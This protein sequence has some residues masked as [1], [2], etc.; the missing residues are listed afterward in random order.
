MASTNSHP[1]YVVHLKQHPSEVSE[2][3]G[4]SKNENEPK[5]RSDIV[6]SVYGEPWYG[7]GAHDFMS[8]DGLVTYGSRGTVKSCNILVKK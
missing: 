1:R 3:G 5:R 7:L 4:A 2:A 6:I 8:S